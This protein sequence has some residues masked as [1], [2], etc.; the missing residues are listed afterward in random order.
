MR[1]DHGHD[2]AR[3]WRGM[4]RDSWEGGHRVPLIVRWPGNVKAGTTSDQLAC[5]TDVMATVAAILGEALP[6]HAAEDS[7]NLLPALLGDA[8][9]P[10]RPHLITQ[11][12]GGFRTLSVRRGSWK[13]LDHPGSGGN[14]YEDNPG[15]APYILPDIAPSAPHQ[16][17]N[18]GDDPGE[19]K[20]LAAAMPEKV[21]EMKT[22]LDKLIK[23]GRSAPG[24]S[25]KE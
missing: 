23:D 24:A 20:N 9:S 18:L 2:G 5:L 12:F 6:D 21:A 1:G 11:A 7:F 25:Q 10:I 16:L 4:K 22:L 13:Y 17:Y 14:R 15:L 19:T 8:E 3:P